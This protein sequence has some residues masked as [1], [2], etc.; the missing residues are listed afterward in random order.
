MVLRAGG[1]VI[2]DDA[3]NASPA[4]VTA[5]LEL[6]SGLPGRHVAVLG[7]MRELGTAHDAGHL[8]A[9]EAA[10]AMLDRLVVVDGGPDGE[11]AGIVEGAL[12]AGLAGDADHRRRRSG[13]RGRRAARRARRG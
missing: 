10:G 13:R 6:L 2:V 8:E 3:Y 4:S 5:A 12:A 9:G 11:A 1:V 7:A